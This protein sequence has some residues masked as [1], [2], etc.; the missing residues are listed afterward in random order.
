MAEA[1]KM[2]IIGYIIR[3]GKKIKRD[4]LPLEEQK[5]LAI[6]WNNAAMETAGFVRVTKPAKK[7]RK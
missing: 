5:R 7:P 6:A 4:E 2:T 3:D 1:K